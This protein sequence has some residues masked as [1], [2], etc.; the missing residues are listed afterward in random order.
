[1]KYLLG[2]GISVLEK[3]KKF[4]VA[5]IFLDNSL[6]YETVVDVSPY[7]GDLKYDI[8]QWGG[9]VAKDEVRFGNLF[10]ETEDPN[11]RKMIDIFAKFP[12]RFPSKFYIFELNKKTL[13]G[14]KKISI[15][16][17][18]NDSNY[19]NGFMSKS[20]LIDPTHI[21]LIPVDYCGLF[22][23]SKEKFYDDFKFMI[24]SGYKNKIH[25]KDNHPI[26]ERKKDTQS[27]NALYETLHG[28][29]FPFK[30]KWN[31]KFLTENFVLGG[32][33]II[34]IELKASNDGTIMF[35]TYDQEFIDYYKNSRNTVDGF[36]VSQSFF[37]MVHDGLLDKYFYEDQ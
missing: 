15:E 24:P 35:E 12:K 5:R 14:K 3:Y 31:G 34:E 8:R 28:Y 22:K 37:A 33:G 19:T 9:D 36:M 29:P 17:M 23:E 20:T 11:I 25:I 27:D 7:S 30:F 32:N 21:F 10:A 16:V 4:P 26:T 1:M 18:N 6:I 2:V 13:L